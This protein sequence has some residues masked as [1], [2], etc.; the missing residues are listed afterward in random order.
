MTVLISPFSYSEKDFFPGAY[1]AG[2]VRAWFGRHLVLCAA[3]E[4]LKGY[5]L[6]AFPHQSA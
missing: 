5:S 4:D 6:G 1:N 2:R 3:D